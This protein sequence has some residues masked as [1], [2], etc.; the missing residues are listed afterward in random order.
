MESNQPDD[1]NNE[2]LSELR[3]ELEELRMNYAIESYKRK[4]QLQEQQLQKHLYELRISEMEKDLTDRQVLQDYAS[5]VKEA[6]PGNVDSSYVLKLQV[7]LRKAADRIAWL[8]EQLKMLTNSCD[9]V[10]KSYHDDIADAIGEKLKA[11]HDLKK[12]V[13][14]LEEDRGKME[15]EYAK[16]ISEQEEKISKLQAEVDA[17]PSPGESSGESDKKS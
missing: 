15:K 14:S 8:E 2:D 17:L 13:A 5:L 4:I 10:L 1:N 16:M 9:N 6:A 3:A 11:E 7:Q 12:M